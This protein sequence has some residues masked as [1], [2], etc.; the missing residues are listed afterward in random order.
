MSKFN[1]RGLC[2]AHPRFAGVIAAVG[3]L[4]LAAVIVLF[5]WNSFA[6]PV[7]E[8]DALRYKEA[9]GLTL[10]ISVAGHL[11]RP[12]HRYGSRHSEIQT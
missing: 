3:T 7:F 5:A 11:L 1:L 6:V 12:R 2:H 8:V 9:L 10:L 4:A